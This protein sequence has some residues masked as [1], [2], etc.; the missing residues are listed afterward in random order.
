MLEYVDVSADRIRLQIDQVGKRYGSRQVLQRVCA[1]LHAGDRLVV[2]GRNG[3]GKSTLLRIIA[4]LVRPSAGSVQLWI[5]GLPV[6]PERRRQVLSFVGPDIHLYRDLTAREH[7]HLVARLRGLRLDTDETISALAS[8]GLAGREDEP[9]K[10][11]STGMLQ[12]L[13]YA[14]AL[15][16]RPRLLLLDEPTANLDVAGIA[17]VDRIVESVS[18][19][20][21]VVIATNDPRDLHYGDYLLPLDSVRDE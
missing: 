10:G 8:V 16:D 21:I 12:R 19:D 4:G 2:M 6:G 11:Y 3:A 1:D 14:L 5:D 20:G 15:L 9:V 7:L 18:A 13:R 17:V